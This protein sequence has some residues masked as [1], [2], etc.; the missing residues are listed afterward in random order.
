M[1]DYDLVVLA[2]AIAFFART[3]SAMVFAPFEIS[4]LAAAWLVPL[5]SRGVAGATRIPLGLLRADALCI[6][7]R[8]AALDR[9]TP[10]GPESRK[11]DLNCQQVLAG[12]SLRLQCGRV[13]DFFHC[14]V[15]RH[16][17]NRIIV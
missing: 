13:F 12:S 5:L 2:V 9:A 16:I 7:A 3:G 6:Y 14:R 10:R 1:L 4:L 11:R 15:L 17:G 8:R